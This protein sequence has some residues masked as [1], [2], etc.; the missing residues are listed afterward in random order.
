M[1]LSEGE[2]KCGVFHKNCRKGNFPLK[3]SNSFINGSSDER[4]ILLTFF[5]IFDGKI[6]CNTYIQ[7]IEKK[8]WKTIFQTKYLPSLQ[9]TVSAVLLGKFQRRIQDNAK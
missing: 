3:L 2:T 8:F 7:L 4:V 1:Q 9:K 5:G 6:S